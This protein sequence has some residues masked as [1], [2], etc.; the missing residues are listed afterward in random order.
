M[1]QCY[2]PCLLPDVTYVLTLVYLLGTPCLNPCIHIVPEF[3]TPFFLSLTSLYSLLTPILQGAIY[4][5]PLFYF[6]LPEE[7]RLCP[8][9]CFMELSA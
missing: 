4:M 2:S 8:S 5:L 3:L 1:R 7:N 6:A 9:Q